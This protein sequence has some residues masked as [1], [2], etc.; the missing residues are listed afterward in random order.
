MH[1][2]DGSRS[3][4]DEGERVVATHSTAATA[5][6]ASCRNRSLVI[7]GLVVLSP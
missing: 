3:I 1:R 6:L 5:I 4:L 7:P 2:G